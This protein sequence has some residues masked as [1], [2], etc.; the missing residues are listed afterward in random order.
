MCALS[1]QAKKNL[2]RLRFEFNCH[3]INTSSLHPQGHGIRSLGHMSDL[4]AVGG[5][6]AKLG[7]AVDIGLELGGE[8]RQ[9]QKEVARLAQHGCRAR[10]LALRVYQLRRIQ[11]VAAVIALVPPSILQKKGRST[12][13]GCSY[14]CF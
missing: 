14:S 5:P 10:Q 9:G 3:C 2:L 8:F 1:K 4:H 13:N 6:S 12:L 7:C 11:Q